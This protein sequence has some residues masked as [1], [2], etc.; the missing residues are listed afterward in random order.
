MQRQR[1]TPIVWLIPLLLVGACSQLS[2]PSRDTPTHLGAAASVQMPLPTYSYTYSGDTRGF[3]FQ[4]PVDFRIT[5]LRVPDESGHGLQNVEVFKLS[6]R[7][8]E[9]SGVATG[10]Q[11]FYRT[12]VPSGEIIATDLSFQAG[13]YVGILGAAGDSNEMHNSYGAGS[14]TSDI[15]GNPVVLERFLT[16]T[17]IVSYGGN[18]PYSSEVGGSIARVEVYVE[19]PAP[20]AVMEPYSIDFETAPANRLSWGVAL[21]KGMNY[22]G[23]GTPKTERVRVKGHPRVNGKLRGGHTATV[24]NL[25][26][27]KRLFVARSKGATTPNATGGLLQLKFVPTG[28]QTS[29]HFGDG[30]VNVKQLT[31]STNPS[32]DGHIKLFGG[33]EYLGR[34][35]LPRTAVGE[36][37]VVP[38]NQEGVGTVSIYATSA[39]AIDDVLFEDEAV[40]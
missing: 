20:V 16:Q 37:V 39:F 26:G 8:P 17:N 30:K 27:G 36:S 7:P 9:Y 3:W 11:V 22:L 18:Q 12:G 4:A 33:G 14:F 31:I 34:V 28:G 35:E 15:L 1:F 40:Q 13:D 6:E 25:Y 23:D 10:G 5:G 24:A 2:G 21:G 38:V 32:F 19:A 29:P